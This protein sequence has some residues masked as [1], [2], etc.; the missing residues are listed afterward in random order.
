MN[1]H[2]AQ[3]KNMASCHAM[4]NAAGS[5]ALL[6]PACRDWWVDGDP[7]EMA[8]DGVLHDWL[9]ECI[10]DEIREHSLPLDADEVE[11]AV[12]DLLRNHGIT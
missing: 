4:P 10:R 1:Y 7:A 8:P 5:A 12:G 2:I 6:A 3:L 11:D 9:A